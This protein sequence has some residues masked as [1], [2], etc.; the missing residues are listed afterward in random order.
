MQKVIDKTNTMLKGKE[1]KFSYIKFLCLLMGRPLTKEF[2]LKYSLE[3]TKSNIIKMFKTEFMS[4][5]KSDYITP[6][7][8]VMF[9]NVNTCNITENV[10]ELMSLMKGVEISFAREKDTD[11]L[12]IIFSGPHT[13]FG[14]RKSDKEKHS[15][16]LGEFG[17]LVV[18]ALENLN[19][20]EPLVMT[21]VVFDMFYEGLA[22][23]KM[24]IQWCFEENLFNEFGFPK[25][26]TE[27]YVRPNE[28]EFSHFST[29]VA[30]KK[31]IEDV[32]TESIVGTEDFR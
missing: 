25:K 12:L 5:M 2:K 17:K 3:E 31:K 26:D 24:W 9:F 1:Y 20:K 28:N 18:Y 4:E 30:L 10:D 19:E 7:G 16:M 13:S 6:D 8:K 15:K 22:N 29:F 27:Y 14:L 32:G 23:N 21:K 11:D